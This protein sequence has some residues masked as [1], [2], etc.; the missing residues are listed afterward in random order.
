[1]DA[2]DEAGL[3]YRLTVFGHVEPRLGTRLLR[4]PAVVLHGS[5]EASD[6][7]RI[8]DDVHVG[9]VPSVWEEAYAYVGVEF[10][11]KGIP[12]L[13]SR[14]GGIPDYVVAG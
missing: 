13:G 3:S 6:L 8:L 7:D 1:M 2:L 12:V 10:L 14:I 9:L 11:A 4:S 5:Y